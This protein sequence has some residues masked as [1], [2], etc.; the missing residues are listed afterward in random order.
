MRKN[1]E[2][3][4]RLYGQSNQNSKALSTQEL[5]TILVSQ[6]RTRCIKCH[7]CMDVC[8]VIKGSFTIEELNRATEQD[9]DVPAVIKA[10]SF[11]CMQC[12]KC[13][14]VC[15]VGIRRDYLVRYLKFKV[16][17]QKPWRY[18]RYLLIR[19]PVLS[20]LGTLGQKLYASLK[21]VT[22]RDVARYMETV[23]L[24]KAEVL[25]YP[26]CY[27]YSVKTVRQT[28]RLL[29]HIGCTYTVLG[30]VST[31][32][33]IP[34]LLQGEFDRADQCMDLLHEKIKRVEPKIVITACAEC[35]EAVSQIKTTW[36]EDFEVMSVAE[37]LLKNIDK[38]PRVKIR[39]KIL[40]HDSCRFTKESP[41]GS[42]ARHVVSTFA[43]LVEHQNSQQTACCYHWNHGYD[44]ASNSRR[45]TYLEDVKKVA[46][47]LAC[48]CLT[49]YEEFKKLR[50]DVEVIDVLQLFED[51]LD[52][53]PG[54]E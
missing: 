38:F 10:F 43:E 1:K 3:G 16:K 54:K 26:G 6:Y 27:I 15:P 17:K 25:F 44:T 2:S 30:G 9:T 50:T 18:K 19:G 11:N 40:V 33:G 22:T 23:P 46:P 14:P 4:T 8:P 34:H 5:M 41:L 48:S 13:V 12:G 36:N 28:V 39:G 47:T 31:C 52:S 20:T 7:R 37:Y 53:L 35:Y 32:C 42:A 51:A 45:V 49:C 24:K 29:D 21:R